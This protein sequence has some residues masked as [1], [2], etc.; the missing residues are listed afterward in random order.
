MLSVFTIVA[1]G[2]PYRYSAE[3]APS[4]GE[5]VTLDKGGAQMRV[6]RSADGGRV[7]IGEVVLDHA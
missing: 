6:L 1:A 7:F 2:V 4:I 3:V 5:V